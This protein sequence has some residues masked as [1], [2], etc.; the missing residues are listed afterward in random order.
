KVNKEDEIY[1]IGDFSFGNDNQ[2][3][4]ILNNLNGKKHL[5]L[6]NH[7]IQKKYWRDENLFVSVEKYKEIKIKNNNYV[8]FHYPIY[9]WNKMH[10]GS[11]HLHG[12]THSDKHKKDIRL[13]N[14]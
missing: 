6:G 12:H 13:K 14:K 2:S 9:S 1:I 10:H 3:K 7:D 5:I 8:L 11:I 4:E